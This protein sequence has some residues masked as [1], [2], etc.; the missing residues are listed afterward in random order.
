MDVK[1]VG[2]PC[3]ECQRLAE[4]MRQVASDLGVMLQ[5]ENLCDCDTPRELRGVMS[6][7]LV[8]DGE[9]KSQGRMPSRDEIVQWLS[10]V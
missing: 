4:M 2:S 5:L 7:A 3:L 8:L 9:V 1:I 10:G 6:P